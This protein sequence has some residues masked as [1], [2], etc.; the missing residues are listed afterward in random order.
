MPTPSELYSLNKAI[1]DL[2]DIVLRLDREQ[3]PQRY[4]EHRLDKNIEKD[5]QYITQK[6]RER[7]IDDN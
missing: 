7:F 3:F 5:R 1:S 2:E 4:M 6:R